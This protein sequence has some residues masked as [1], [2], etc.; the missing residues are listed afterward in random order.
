MNAPDA[1]CAGHFLG[2]AK[3]SANKTSAKRWVGLSSAVLRTIF[4]R[5][6]HI[7]GALRHLLCDIIGWVVPATA[8]DKTI[9]VIGE[10]P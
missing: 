2:W 3:T 5:A 9:N 4:W 7:N 6:Q 8:S 10:M 1:W